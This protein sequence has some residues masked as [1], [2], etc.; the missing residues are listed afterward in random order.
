MSIFSLP[1]L[2]RSTSIVAVVGARGGAGDRRL[3][4]AA[5]LGRDLEAQRLRL[6]VLERQG[7]D[8]GV[9]RAAL[10]ALH[11]GQLPEVGGVALAGRAAK[12]VGDQPGSGDRRVGSVGRVGIG[13]AERDFIAGAMRRER[14]AVARPTPRPQPKTSAAAAQIHRPRMILTPL[15]D[16]CGLLTPF[17]TANLGRRISWRL[18]PRR[19]SGPKLPASGVRSCASSGSSS[20]AQRLVVVRPRHAIARRQLALEQAGALQLVEPRQVADLLQTEMDQEFVR[21]CRR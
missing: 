12:F 11:L 21:S 10:G 2:M 13:A 5:G 19:R 17:V 8:V 9:D 14:R 7:A 6:A 4:R 20:G 3:R 15:A 1:G 16:H 18:S